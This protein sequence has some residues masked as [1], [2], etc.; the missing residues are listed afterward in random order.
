MRELVLD[1]VQRL[2]QLY[3]EVSVRERDLDDL[4][5]RANEKLKKKTTDPETQ[6]PHE[7]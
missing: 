1:I 6:G 4:F 7:G 3:E 2:T 5:S